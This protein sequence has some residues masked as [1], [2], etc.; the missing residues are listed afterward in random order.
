MN[1]LKYHFYGI[2][3]HAPHTYLNH[4]HTNIFAESTDLECVQIHY[5]LTRFIYRIRL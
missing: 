5:F 2:L 3:F 1:I 4:Y